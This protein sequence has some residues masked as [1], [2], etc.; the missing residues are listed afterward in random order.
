MQV[1]EYHMPYP[2]PLNN[3]DVAL[4]DALDIALDYLEFTGQAYPFSETERLCAHTILNAWLA[5]TTH[6]I[7]LANDAICVIE[8]RLAPLTKRKFPQAAC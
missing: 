1:L 3:P 5:G 4:Q 2:W 7:R 6:R 8:K